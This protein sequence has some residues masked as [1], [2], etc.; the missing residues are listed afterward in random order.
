MTDY[1]FEDGN[2]RVLA[3]P[4]SW[5]EGSANA[6]LQKVAARPGVLAAIGMPDLHP[7]HKGPVGSVIQTDGRIFPDLIG[8]DI[9]C[10]MTLFAIAGDRRRISLDRMEK[11]LRNRPIDDTDPADMDLPDDL[12]PY[13]GTLGTLGFG[14][15]FAELQ[16]S[17]SSSSH[18]PGL[19]KDQLALLIHS[20]SRAYG[21]A[22][23]ARHA[24]GNEG[25]RGPDRVA[26][27]SDHDA[28]VAFAALNRRVIG[29]RMLAILGLRGNVIL[30]VPHNLVTLT[31]EGAIHRKGAAAFASGLSIVAGSRATPSH[32]VVPGD[33]AMLS[34]DSVAHG[35]GRKRDRR[36]ALARQKHRDQ[37]TSQRMRR[38][39]TGRVICNDSRLVKEEA[40]EAYKD[41]RQVV[42][43]LECFGIARSVMALEPLLTV[44]QAE[45]YR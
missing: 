9:G 37:E 43:D 42:G 40:P 26:Y 3:S 11:A 1:H 41:I 29:E 6:Q 25:L 30:D 39:E 31:S 2:C 34:F 7:G 38:R 22:V 13:R 35:C 20:G 24:A 44:K 12:E 45:E 10:G 23:F 32:I 27:L 14:N 18:V 4:S 21:A 8:T 17:T 33:R 19:E 16:A 15:H 5:I 28:A 36:A